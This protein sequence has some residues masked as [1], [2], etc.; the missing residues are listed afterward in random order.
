MTDL[1]LYVG[2]G[3]SVIMA[4]FGVRET[5]FYIECQSKTY[6]IR[7]AQITANMLEANHR[8]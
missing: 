1:E 4:L 7:V 8:P 5:L 3:S 2:D 6:G